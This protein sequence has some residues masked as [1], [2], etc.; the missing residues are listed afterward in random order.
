M[1]MDCY[2]YFSLQNSN[3]DAPA[4]VGLHEGPAAEPVKIEGGSPAL[5]SSPKKM[6]IDNQVS[7]LNI[8]KL[9][10]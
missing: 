8:L 10:V 3:T 5:Q 4:S 1:Q 2:C 9:F 6:E 7:F